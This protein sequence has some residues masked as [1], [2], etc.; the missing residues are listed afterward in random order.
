M[1]K[2]ARPICG[3]QL[4]KG[5]KKYWKLLGIIIWLIIGGCASDKIKALNQPGKYYFDFTAV[6]ED[7]KG[8]FDEEGVPLTDYGG[9]LGTQY[10][11]VGIAQYALGNW[12]L[13]LNSGKVRYKRQFLKIAS[14]LC[15]NLVSK[16][17]FGVWEYRFDYPRFQLKCPW[18]SAMAQGLGISVLVR[19]YQLTKDER[20]LNCA[21]LAL[22][23]FEVPIKQG[24][25]LY[26]DT[27]GF[28]WYEEYPS[29]IDP[30]HVLNGF[31]FAL[32]GPYDFYRV[33][34]DS[35]AHRIFEEGI[36]TLVANIERYDMGFWSRYDLTNL[37]GKDI[38]V[39]RFVTARKHPSFPHPIDKIVLHS[40]AE[41]SEALLTVLDVGSDGDTKDIAV[42]GARLYYS[43]G[44]QDWGDAY[45]LDGR[46]VRNYE[47]RR[48]RYAHAPFEFR[49]DFSPSISYC[50]EI[51]YKDVTTEPLYVELYA[52][53]V[54]YIRFAKIK[55]AGDG[56][57]K[58]MMIEIPQGLLLFTRGTSVKYH[59]WHIKQLKLLYEITDIT[60]FKKY[61]QTFREYENAVLSSLWWDEIQNAIRGRS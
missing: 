4:L 10:Q 17:N 46:T 7:W 34:G 61:A 28:I 54:K 5:M 15:E 11:P 26:E 60:L 30:P 20:Y 14:W 16:G 19:A 2:K 9:Q 21:K 47:D 6:A 3:K 53:G 29:S 39:F 24:G 36:K 41:D 22:G 58:K 1:K 50:L 45:I 57:W 51:E 56:T 37:S 13:F 23:A 8:P 48:G 55:G 25:I 35:K 31:I 33:T 59:R 42:Y 40:V 44:Y 49:I 27:K 52:K 32:L 38:Y 18:P 12:N 43:P